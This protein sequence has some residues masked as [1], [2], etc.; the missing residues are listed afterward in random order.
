MVLG[1]AGSD[2]LGMHQLDHPSEAFDAGRVRWDKQA[3]DVAGTSRL[4]AQQVLGELVGRAAQTVSGGAASSL[5][6]V[7][8]DEGAD[9]ARDGGW[10]AADVLAGGVEG[11][12]RGGQR[13][14]DGVPRRIEGVSPA[15]GQAHPELGELVEG[16]RRAIEPPGVVS[17]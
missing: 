10:V 11:G 14:R 16:I 5:R 12:E 1:V 2:C 7:D 4:Q 6:L 8:D 9:G 13:A 15:S 3:G 17:R